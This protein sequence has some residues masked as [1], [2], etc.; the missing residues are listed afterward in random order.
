LIDEYG[1]LDV[2]RHTMFCLWLMGQGKVNVPPAWLTA[3]LKGDWSA[4]RGM[5]IGRMRTVVRLRVDENTFAEFAC[6]MRKRNK[7]TNAKAPG[8]E[9]AL[10]GLFSIWQM[11]DHA[12]D[13]LKYHD[14]IDPGD[15]CLHEIVE[16]FLFGRTRPGLSKPGQAKMTPQSYRSN[17][18]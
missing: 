13:T 14:I 10:L 17:Y 7:G 15:A 11:G 12:V 8:A 5:P 16:A 9:N 1:E 4:P 6:E 18:A 3:S 2:Q